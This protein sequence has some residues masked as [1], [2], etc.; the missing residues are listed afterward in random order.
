VSAKASVVCGLVVGLLLLV[1]LTLTRRPADTPST[2]EAAVGASQRPAVGVHS[3]LLWWGVSEADQERSLDAVADS[4]ATWVRLDLGWCS[5]Q[6]VGPAGWDRSYLARA[7]RAVDLARARDLQVLMV[8][9][10]TPGWANG[11][12][13]RTVPPDDPSTYAAA[14][15][16]LA[17]SFAGRVDAWEVWNEQN[18]DDFWAGADPARYVALLRLA[19]PAI[20]AADPGALVVMGGLMHNDDAWVRAAY[21]AG[22][23]GWFDVLATHPYSGG[24]SPDDDRGPL[25]AGDDLTLP[26]VADVRA[27]MVAHGDASVPIWFTEYG[28]SAHANSLG[29]PDWSTGVSRRDQARYAV[30]AVELV[31]ARYPYVRLMVW[32]NDRARQDAG[33]HLAG[34]GLLSR[35]FAPTPAYRELS[36]FLHA[37][38]PWRVDVAA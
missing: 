22:A 1:G 37:T 36:H 13:D 5:A 12:Q 29:E 38:R 7:D 16:R 6:A 10:C 32:Y 27:V 24:R 11:G 31:A 8:L 26:G 33:T 14:A 15:S 21:E 18:S 35:D 19:Y 23:A 9:W 30:A 2:D 25:P 28:W 4:G 20:K 3:H 17:T 34:Y